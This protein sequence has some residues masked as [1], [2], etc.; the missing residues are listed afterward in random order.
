MQKALRKVVAFVLVDNNW[1]M[2]T[3][4][5]LGRGITALPTAPVLQK[6][7]GVHFDYDNKITKEDGTYCKFQMQ[8]N[9]GDI[10]KSI[11]NWRE[12]HGG[13]HSV[14]ADVFVKKGGTKKDIEK[15]L[16]EAIAGIR[17]V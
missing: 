12:A 11:K 6:R 9:A 13:T 7:L 2:L 1:K 8:P 4:P 14:M 10:P 5:T 16:R 15:A 3:D 17:G